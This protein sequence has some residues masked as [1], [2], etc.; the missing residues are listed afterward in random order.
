M[1]NCNNLSFAAKIEPATAS[2]F[3]PVSK[4]LTRGRICWKQE[5]RALMG[6]QFWGATHF[7]HSQNFHGEFSLLPSPYNPDDPLAC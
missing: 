2:F 4:S 1:I 6:F 5:A 7:R 3:S